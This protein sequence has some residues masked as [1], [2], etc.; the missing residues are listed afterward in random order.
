MEELISLLKSINYNITRLNEKLDDLYS[1]EEEGQDLLLTGINNLIRSVRELNEDLD[2][3]MDKAD[4]RLAGIRKDTLTVSTCIR[5]IDPDTGKLSRNCIWSM[6]GDIRRSIYI[7]DPKT[8]RP[9]ESCIWNMI[10]NLE[11]ALVEFE[12]EDEE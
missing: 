12:D 6:L 11:S 4:E 5:D 7:V 3:R 9:S 2:T 10:S 1:K 8:G